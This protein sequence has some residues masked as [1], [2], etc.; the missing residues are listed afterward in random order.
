M[1][2]SN[3]TRT[4]TAG[5]AAL[6]LLGSSVVGMQMV[7]ERR[8]APADLPQEILYVTSPA[9]LQRLALSFDAIVADIYW[10]RAIQYFGG[11]RLSQHA[12]RKYEL[13]YPL[14]DLTTSL[15]PHF[16]IAYRFGA[17]FLS[18]NP[19][20]GPGRSDLAIRLLGK[21]MAA[22]PEKWEYAY[23]A[24]FVYYRRGDYAEAVKWF[25]RAADSPGSPFWIRPLI[26]VV[27]A[28][29]GDTNSARVVW[30]SMLE[31]DMEFMRDEAARR[32]QQLDAIDQIAQL[33]TIVQTYA[34]RTG[35]NPRS[36]GDLIRMR[37]IPGV[38]V[39]PT[40]R[41]YALDPQ[42]GDID[43][44]MASRLWPLTMERPS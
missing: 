14:L 40:G 43:V 5:V 23:D 9:M 16:A 27:Q 19:P 28:E 33:E 3:R 41:P 32:L 4:R 10:M 22:H 24:G 38:P 31:S 42:S 39:D 6:L 44:D 30:R 34:Q 26:A 21:G 12:D 15:D 36:W 11:T 29:R 8:Y 7:R 25:T 13:L 2:S 37:M 20:G 1:T 35:G 18:E 17:F